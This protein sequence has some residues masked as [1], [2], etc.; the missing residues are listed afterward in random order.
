MKKEMC[1]WKGKDVSG[2]EAVRDPKTGESVVSLSFDHAG[3]AAFAEAT[4]RLTGQ[5]IGIYMDET[6]ISAPVVRQAITDGTAMISGMNSPEEAKQ[7]AEKIRAGALPFSMKTTNYNTIS[8]TLG[9]Q[10][11][12]SMAAAG[13]FSLLLICLFMMTY[14]RLPGN[15][16]LPD[17][18]VSDVIAGAGN[19]DSPVYDYTAGY[20]RADSL[21]RNG[22]GCEYYHQRADQ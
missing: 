15:C 21:G 7:L 22:G 19:F 1:W 14:Y 9:N 18:A 12:Q 11:L 2:S 4:G 10:A 13:L 5:R 16:K 3:A 20:C 8:P 17:A 6:L